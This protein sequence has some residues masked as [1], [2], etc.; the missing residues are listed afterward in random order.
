M[1]AKKTIL[2]GTRFTRFIVIQFHN[3]IRGTAQYLCKCDCGNERLIWQH[4]L[5]SGASRSCGCLRD[6]ISAVQSITH[7]HSING[8]ISKEYMSWSRAKARCL[9]E[10]SERFKDYGGR[11]IRMCERWLISFE[12]FLLDMGPCPEGFS[13]ER[14][15]NDGNYEPGNCCWADRITQGNNKRNNVKLNYNGQLFTV[16]QLARLASLKPETLRKRMERGWS[17]EMAMTPLSAADSHG[18]VR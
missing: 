18:T 16:P 5:T 1:P 8:Q 14:L 2:P 13:I 4:N 6:S 15:N 9:N 17:L 7:G 3:R 10:N 12:N 11:G